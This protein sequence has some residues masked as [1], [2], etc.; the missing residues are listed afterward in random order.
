[1]TSV[2]LLVIQPTPFCNMNCSYCYLP[3]KSNPNKISI[4]TVG[5]LIDTLINDKILSGHLSIVW[6]AGEPLV[7]PPSFYKPLFLLIAQKLKTLGVSVQHAIQTNGTLLSQEWCDFINEQGIRI[8]VSIDGP[9]EVH[10]ANRKMRNGK[11]TFDKVIEG[12]NLLKSNNIQYHAIAVVNETSI[13]DPNG[14]YD[15]FYKHGFYEL[16]LNIE[17][18]EGVHE[19]SAIFSD[20]L[21]EKVFKFYDSL[22]SLYLESDKH[23]R[24]REFDRSIDAIL[25]DPNHLDITKLVA[26]THQNKPMAIISIDY[27]GNFSTFSPELIGQ[28]SK[29]FSDFIFGNVHTSGFNSAGKKPLLQHI[30]HEIKNGIKQCKRDCG[31]FHVCGGGAPANKYFENGTFNSSETKYCK[32]NIKVPTQIV[33]S[34]LEKKLLI[35][36]L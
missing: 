36:A 21:Y 8:G 22:F 12:I 15:F 29:E 10:D 20:S 30:T 19:Q 28:K 23:M 1:M 26:E 34:Y 35:T 33:L 25:R 3:D 16:G 11:G 24:I 17:E 31:Y 18:V 5:C 9:R 14:F 13:R 32:Y 7:L 2:D 4:E 6:H 27:K